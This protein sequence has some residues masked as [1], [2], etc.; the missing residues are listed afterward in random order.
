MNRVVLGYDDMKV[1]RDKRALFPQRTIMLWLTVRN[2]TTT[3]C[4]TA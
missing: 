3:E 4:L 1:Y 2:F